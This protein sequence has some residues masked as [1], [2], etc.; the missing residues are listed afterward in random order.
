MSNYYVGEVTY[1]TIC[2]DEHE[3]QV[4]AVVAKHVQMLDDTL[5]DEREKH[6]KQ[7]AKLAKTATK[8][9]NVVAERIMLNLA[10]GTEPSR[11]DKRFREHFDAN[12]SC[13]TH[14][15]NFFERSDGGE[16]VLEFKHEVKRRIVRALEGKTRTD[17]DYE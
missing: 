14:G 8:D 1:K 3:Y 15:L 13:L 6:E 16:P 7:I 4:P 10:S 17:E 12:E 5:E 2:I 11:T 9:F